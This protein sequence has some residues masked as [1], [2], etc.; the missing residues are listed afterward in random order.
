MNNPPHKD[1][2]DHLAFMTPKEMSKEHTDGV[3]RVNIK[4]KQTPKVKEFNKIL[5]K[6]KN[7]HTDGERVLREEFEANFLDG[8]KLEDSKG[9]TFTAKGAFDVYLFAKETTRLETVREV[10][11]KI[12]II[13]RKQISVLRKTI[14]KQGEL[15]SVQA[16]LI[17]KKEE[18][19]EVLSDTIKIMDEKKH[20]KI[21]KK[22]KTYDND[23]PKQ[24]I[25]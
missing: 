17:I 9:T 18:L 16:K 3:K 13:L 6:M 19:I 2:K 21:M 23:Q 20:K 25:P 7:K 10:E 24:N 4:L 15:V 12:E 8:N 22:L 11:G 5:N 14:K 1:K